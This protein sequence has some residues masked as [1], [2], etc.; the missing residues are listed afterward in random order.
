[1]QASTAPS[2]LSRPAEGLRCLLASNP[3]PMTQKGT[4]TWLLGEGEVAVIDPGPALPA[5]LASILAALA[6]GERI[7]HI[8]VTHAHLDHSGLARPLAEATG[9]PVLAFGDAQAGRSARMQALT[10]AGLVPGGEGIDADFVPDIALADGARVSA[11]SW[12]L[13]ALHTPGHFGNH[14]SFLW[15]GCA[16]SG[17]HVMG[18][19]ST[20]ISPPDGDLADYLAS[21]DRLAAAAPAR[22]FCGH[23][24]PVDDPAA[25]IA[26]LA[27]HRRD[28]ST[29]IL[30][31]LAEAPCDIA[32]LVSR[33]YADTPAALHPAAARNVLAHLID[34]EENKLISS[35]HNPGTPRRYTLR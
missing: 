8:F 2:A 20:L 16:F 17:D 12:A 27:R 10:A 24:A 33:L 1:M 22:L 23:G 28:R 30:A 34:L 31:A 25:R 7:T 19:A 6:P 21:L 14:L 11:A 29:Q 5:H 3:S 35:R 4:N 15:Q 9:A 26:E 13:E 32:T 18:W